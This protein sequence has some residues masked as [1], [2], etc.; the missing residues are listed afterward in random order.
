M[1]RFV[2]PPLRR[3]LG[4]ALERARTAAGLT[5]QQAAEKLACSPARLSRKEAGYE[6]VTV[7]DLFQVADAYGTSAPELVAHA[8]RLHAGYLVLQ[9]T[10][11]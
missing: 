11:A 5:Q 6:A 8:A 3:A 7:A 4:R 10:G 9:E 1:K 2:D